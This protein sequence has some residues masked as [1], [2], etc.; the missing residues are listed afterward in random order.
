[1]GLNGLTHW[2]VSSPTKSPKKTAEVCSVGKSTRAMQPWFNRNWSTSLSIFAWARFLLGFWFQIC[3]L[4]SLIMSQCLFF[5]GHL[6]SW[7]PQNV[8]I[9]RMCFNDI[10][11]EAWRGNWCQFLKIIFHFSEC[12]GIWWGLT[13][14]R[15]WIRIWLGLTKQNRNLTNKSGGIV[16]C[17]WGSKI[18]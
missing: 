10:F 12:D 1:M 7:P 6:I 2:V 16:G 8:K 18:A 3:N 11:E 17:N 5:W 14:H 4:C 9:F 15:D 13:F